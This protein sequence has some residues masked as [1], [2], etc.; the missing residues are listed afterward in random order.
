MQA[1]VQS[2]LA[3]GIDDNEASLLEPMLDIQVGATG[4][5]QET[6]QEMEIEE[7]A[8][9]A[10]SIA[11]PEAE[12]ERREVQV[13]REREGVWQ[14]KTRARQ[15]LPSGNHWHW[16]AREGHSLGC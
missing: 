11:N 15:T 5:S 8:A 1:E 6:F 12:E 2:I 16:H 13:K 3:T 7:D 4:A 9:L 14:E 10:A